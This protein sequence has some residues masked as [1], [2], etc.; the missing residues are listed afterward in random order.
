MR[1][2]EV[3]SFFEGSGEVVAGFEAAG[4][5]DLG[6]GLGGSLAEEC[7]GFPK[8]AF[9]EEFEGGEVGD[10]SAVVGET[11]AAQVA[12]VSH[13]LEGPGVIEM[14]GQGVEEH[15]NAAVSRGE[16][17]VEGDIFFLEQLQQLQ[18]ELI[19]EKLQAGLDSFG[20]GVLNGLS[21]VFE[22]LF[23]FS[24]SLPY[25]LFI[26]AE[27]LGEPLEVGRCEDEP[28]GPEPGVVGSSHADIQN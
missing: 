12:V 13:F 24:V 10:F 11:G 9:H 16:V 20:Q 28:L 26:E 15:F 7:L 6:N 1:G 18:K 17:G 21:D 2:G 19:D 23:D 4:Q 22:A 8:A 3:E 5:G 14:V 27:E 25:R